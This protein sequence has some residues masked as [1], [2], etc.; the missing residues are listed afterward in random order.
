[1]D[2]RAILGRILGV[3]LETLNCKN[4]AKS[5]ML[6][7]ISRRSTSTLCNLVVGVGVVVVVMVVVSSCSIGSM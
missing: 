3:L 7:F 5:V 2:I 6:Q 1:M 4:F